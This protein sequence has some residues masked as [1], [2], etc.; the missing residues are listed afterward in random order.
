MPPDVCPSRSACSVDTER[1]R[2]ADLTDTNAGRILSL[3]GSVAEPGEGAAT[4]ATVNAQ[5]TSA[6]PNGLVPTVTLLTPPKP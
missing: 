1:I 4:H 3:G 6:R 5:R 2:G